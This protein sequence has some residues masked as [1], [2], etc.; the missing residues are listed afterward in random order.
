MEYKT[1]PGLVVKSFIGRN[2]AVSG[3]ASVYNIADDH[4]DIIVQGAFAGINV[5]KVKFLWQHDDRNPIGI[6][7][8]AS[9]DDYGLKVNAVINS[10]TTVGKEA[11]ALVKQGAVNALSIGFY[12]KSAKHNKSGNRL[13]TKAELVEVSI[14]TFP[15]NKHARIQQIEYVDKSLPAALK[16]LE[17]T[18]NLINRSY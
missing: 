1:A 2:M 6:I 13:I 3:Y 16:K 10:K 15:A 11:I 14:V 7:K 18:M 8:A 9:E 17:N 5:R 4:N 12:I